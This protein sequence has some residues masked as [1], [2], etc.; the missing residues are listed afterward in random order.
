MWTAQ[1]DCLSGLPTAVLVNS[2]L[3][4][5]VLGLDNPGSKLGPQS[6]VPSR[7]PDSRVQSGLVASQGILKAYRRG[8]LIENLRYKR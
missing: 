8:I 5:V 6:Q 4:P 2:C 3:E 1:G 7:G